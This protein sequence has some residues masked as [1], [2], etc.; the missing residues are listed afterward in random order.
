SVVSSTMLARM[1]AA[2]G[3]ACVTTLTGFKW[4]SRAAGTGR[5]LFG[6]EE[7]IGFAVD[8]LVADKDGLSAALA[9]C[10]LATRLA[11]D[12]ATLLTRLDELEETYG[13]HSGGAL[14]VRAEGEGG[15][16]ALAGALAALTREAPT[17]LGGESVA[18]VVDLAQGWHGLVT[19]GVLFELARGRVIVRPSGTEAK[20]KAYVELVEDAGEDLA[21]TRMRLAVA[22]A[23]VLD[24]LAARL[25]V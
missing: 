5:L 19:E 22:V 2:A 4:I 11:R 10:A 16:E 7:A 12:G 1:A 3:V 21:A 14:S 13:V 17:E 18:N 24:D 6:Y 8:P 15:L 23:A 20:L 25:R 9:I